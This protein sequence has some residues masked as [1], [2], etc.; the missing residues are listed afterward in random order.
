MKFSLELQ[1]LETQCAG[2]RSQGFGGSGCLA[3]RGSINSFSIYPGRILHSL[4][5]PHCALN[6][7]EP[8]LDGQGDNFF[9]SH[10][11]HLPVDRLENNF[12]IIGR[13]GYFGK[14]D[15]GRLKCSVRTPEVG[16]LNPCSSAFCKSFSFYNIDVG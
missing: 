11:L 3:Q 6:K 7:C 5:S 9:M 16:A 13:C 12:Q 15:F 8:Q 4:L 14:A 10:G 2:G 1:F